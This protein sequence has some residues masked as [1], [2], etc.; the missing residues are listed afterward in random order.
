MVSVHTH[1]LLH[2]FKVFFFTLRIKLDT[3]SNAE[4]V[5]NDFTEL[6]VRLQL[7]K[8]QPLTLILEI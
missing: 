3:V 1:S 5:C 6:R 8:H 4:D 2:I 7:S